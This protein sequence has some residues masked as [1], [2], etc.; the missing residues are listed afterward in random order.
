MLLILLNNFSY[1]FWISEDVS[2]EDIQ[3]PVCMYYLCTVL[4]FY[5]I[6]LTVGGLDLNVDFPGFI[7]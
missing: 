6:L 5:E 7:D 3:I 4:M 2:K 1:F